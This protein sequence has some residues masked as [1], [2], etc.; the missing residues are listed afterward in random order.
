[1]IRAAM[2]DFWAGKNPTLQWPLHHPLAPATAFYFSKFR[3]DSGPSGLNYRG[4][5]DDDAVFKY[6][7]VIHT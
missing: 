4:G 3:Q 5:P 2:V 6:S 7:V 1:M